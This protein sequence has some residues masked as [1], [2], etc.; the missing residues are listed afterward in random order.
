MI[1]DIEGCKVECRDL[2]AYET[3]LSKGDLYVSDGKLFTCREIERE[4]C[5]YPR[6][7]CKHFPESGHPAFVFSEEKPQP[8]NGKDCYRVVAIDGEA[9]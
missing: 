3:D 6:K 7:H 9:L 4:S 2:S 1:F 5:E 8:H